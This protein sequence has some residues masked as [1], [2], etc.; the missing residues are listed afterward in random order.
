[1]QHFHISQFRV[2]HSQCLGAWEML[3]L[4][5]KNS[6]ERVP[7]SHSV[8]KSKRWHGHAS[9][10]WLGDFEWNVFKTKQMHPEHQ[11]WLVLIKTVTGSNLIPQRTISFCVK[12]SIHF[13]SLHIPDNTASIFTSI[14]SVPASKLQDDNPRVKGRFSYFVVYEG[15]F[16]PGTSCASAVWISLW[17]SVEQLDTALAMRQNLRRRISLSSR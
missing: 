12:E 5:Q 7:G 14:Q 16:S 15:C 17:S 2:S 8:A 9:T 6:N 1:M 10:C 3:L 11:S 13:F 4:K